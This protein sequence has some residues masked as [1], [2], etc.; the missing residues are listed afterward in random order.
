MAEIRP[1]VIVALDSLYLRRQALELGAQVAMRQ[2]RPLT[3]LVIENP[4]LFHAAELPFVQE[5]DRLCGFLRPFD[6]PR[7]EA[8]FQHRIAQIHRWLIEIETR[9]ALPGGLEIRRGHYLETALAAAQ[10]GDFLVFGT[11]R[12]WQTIRRAPVWVW[13]EDSPSAEQA[14]ALGRELA[15]EEGCRLRLAGPASLPIGEFVPT[16]S[17]GF[18]NLLERQGCTAVVCPKTSPL[19]KELPTR[20]RCPV[21]LV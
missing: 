19:A 18:L 14:L 12:E 15:R 11:Y 2:R 20:A 13:Y 16:D 3:V 8:L 5:I 4:A 17:E 10:E 9:L 21:I 6:L 1:Q 7:L